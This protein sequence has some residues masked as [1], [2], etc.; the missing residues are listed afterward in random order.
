ME[1]E[2]KM[3]AKS[4]GE[5]GSWSAG[6]IQVVMNARY[7]AAGVANVSPIQSQPTPVDFEGQASLR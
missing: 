5:G 2:A 6:A 7:P 4:L 3:V 1:S